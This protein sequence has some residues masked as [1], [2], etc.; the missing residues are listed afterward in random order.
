MET[1]VFDL[2]GVIARHQS[3]VGKDRLAAASGMP[4]VAFWKAYWT[5]CPL[6]DRAT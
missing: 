4:A 6:Y 5:L 2:F 3:A 1:M